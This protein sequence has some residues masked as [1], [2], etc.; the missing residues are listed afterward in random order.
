MKGEIHQEMI[1]I[2]YNIQSNCNLEKESQFIT[3]FVDHYITKCS[4]IT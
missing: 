3:P 4:D 1:N 2:K